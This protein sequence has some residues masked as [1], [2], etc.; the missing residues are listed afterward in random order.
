[1]RAPPG[2]G[3]PPAGRALRPGTR[4]TRTAAAGRA[5]RTG[6]F[7]L[8]VCGKNGLI[9]N[10]TICQIGCEPIRL[11]SQD[12]LEIGGKRMFFLLPLE[13]EVNSVR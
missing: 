2:R 8:I 9:H 13:D 10:G 12:E 6:H 4:L 5:G 7:E 1:M 3:R 11:A